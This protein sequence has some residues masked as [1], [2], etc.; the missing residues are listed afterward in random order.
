[1]PNCAN[2]AEGWPEFANPTEL[3]GNSVWSQ[4]FHK[5]YG[6]IPSIGYPICV[7][8]FTQM[9]GRGGL[10]NKV[11]ACSAVTYGNSGNGKLVDKMSD[12]CDV[13]KGGG[14]ASYI[15][16]ERNTRHAVPDNMWFESAHIT[17]GGDKGATWYYLMFG[18]AVWAYTGKTKVFGDHPDAT[19]FFLSKACSDDASHTT[20]PKT[21]CELDF[22]NIFVQALSQGLDSLQFT[23]HF[24]CGCGEDGPS[25]WTG[26]SKLCNTEIIDLQGNGLKA[27]GNYKAGW[28]AQ[29]DC[30]CDGSKGYGNCKGYGV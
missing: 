21:E 8:A 29:N 30:D 20:S 7:G 2:A 19:T 26:H 1:M 5:V 6:E 27:C 23:E 28:A 9:P 4:Y 24:D 17:F 16:N 22:D 12:C 3:E 25:S 13:G 15:Y 10:S 14:Q 18:S 11:D